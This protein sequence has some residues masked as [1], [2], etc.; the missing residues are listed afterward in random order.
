MTKGLKVGAGVLAFCLCLPAIAAAQV[1]VKGGIVFSDIVGGDNNDSRWMTGWSAG[2]FGSA[3]IASGFYF[4]PE[5]LYTRKGAKAA[6]ILGGSDLKAQ[7][8]YVEVPLLFRL[9]PSAGPVGLDILG[10]VAPAFK[11][12]ARLVNDAGDEEDISDEIKSV[13]AGVVA[14]LGFHVGGF[15]VEGRWTEG[16]VK[17]LDVEGATSRNRV[18]SVLAAIGF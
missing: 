17:L 10:G 7:L 8:D 15:F 9:S 5:V 13:D 2:G 6:P 11:V 18:I 3:R 14:G 16:L 4:Q 12:R 1:G